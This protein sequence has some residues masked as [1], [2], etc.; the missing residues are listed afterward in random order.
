L[1]VVK[2]IAVN[3]VVIVAP[4][5]PEGLGPIVYVVEPRNVNL[6]AAD[7]RAEAQRA[8]QTAL[9]R[10]VERGMGLSGYL[11]ST[12]ALVL[13][14]EVSRQDVV[15]YVANKLGGAHFD[16]N[17]KGGSLELLDKKLATYK[18]KGRPEAIFAYAELLSIAE[19]VARSSDAS[20]F[21]EAYAK[22]R[23]TAERESR[24]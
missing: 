13:G 19:T 17:R 24:D 1:T 6:I 16:T 23:R 18:P 14:N 20:R 12:A 9:G 2:D 15:L 10:R 11:R 3:S 22:V 4:G 5:Y 21:R 8:F 7:P